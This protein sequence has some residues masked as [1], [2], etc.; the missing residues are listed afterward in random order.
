MFNKIDSTGIFGRNLELYFPLLLISKVLGEDIFSDILNIIGTL[1]ASKKEVEYGESKDI[2]LI[3]FIAQKDDDI[4][5]YVYV[6]ELFN[7]FVLFS[8]A[9]KDRDSEVNITWFG[10][11]LRRLN[12]LT[13]VKRDN[14]GK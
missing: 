14:R 13:Q 10:S 6:S 3:E 9:S 8:G 11:A 5:S 1:N 2:S 4:I 12:L 7:E